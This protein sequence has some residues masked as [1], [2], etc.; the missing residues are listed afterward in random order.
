MKKLLALL[1]AFVMVFSVF[2]G[3]QG[4][5]PDDTKGQNVGVDTKPGKTDETQNTESEYPEYLNLDSAY[6]II[7]DEYA[8]TIKLKVAVVQPANGGEW[9]NLWISKYLKEKYNVEFEVTSY[10]SEQAA[11]TKQLMFA[12]GE[13]P[14]LILNFGL[15][16]TDLLDYGQE[17][18]LLLAMDEYMDETL[19]PNLLSIYNSDPNYKRTFAAPDGHLY[20]LP[21]F[22]VIDQDT[23]PGARIFV[24]K[25]VLDQ[26]GVAMPRTL[27]EF[28]DAMYKVKE[29]DING[30][31]DENTPIAGGIEDQGAGFYILNALGYLMD[32]FTAEYNYGFCPAV[33]DGEV[34]IPAYDMDVFQEYLKIMNQFYNDGIISPDY[35]TL[36]DTVSTMQLQSGQS[37]VFRDP[38]Y[39]KGIETWDN[40]KALYP[41]TSDWQTEPEWTGYSYGSTGGFVIS[42]ETE[43]PELCMRIADAFCNVTTDDPYAFWIGPG[44]E[45]EW[46]YGYVNEEWNPETNTTFWDTEKL[47]EGVDLMTYLF[48]YLAGW[49]PIYGLVHSTAAMV[50]HVE[51]MGYE[52]DGVKIYDPTNPDDNYRI[53]VRENQKPY[54]TAG[55]PK[56][57]FVDAETGEQLTELKT[58]IRPYVAEQVALFIT[59]RRPLSETDDF[60]KELEDMGIKDLLEIYQNVYKNAQ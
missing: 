54:A 46:N 42:A 51:V 58:L 47:P 21:N 11:T 31:G 5:V 28:I 53:T 45:S 32:G 24:D 2:A 29:A 7:K 15:S 26:I 22:A 14:D 16:T 35:F 56:V 33:R 10:L 55:F 20:S 12:D 23:M 43:Y 48:G 60:V 44:P 50:R 1:L 38:V 41:L 6:P 19:T 8:G 57:Y 59:G 27:N 25:S 36:D 13:L 39:T 49:Q 17:Q 37:V 40:W 4:D 52:W 30:L 34:V 3:C 9:E 18:G